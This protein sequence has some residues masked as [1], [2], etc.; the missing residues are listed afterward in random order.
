M[1]CNPH[2]SL[3]DFNTD[4]YISE[5]KSKIILFRGPHGPL[6]MKFLPIILLSIYRR[7]FNLSKRKI[8]K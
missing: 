5:E 2:K 6:K 3:K 4:A 7:S 1:L 8:N